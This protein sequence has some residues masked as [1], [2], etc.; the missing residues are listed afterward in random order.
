[1]LIDLYCSLPLV[2]CFDGE[3]DDPNA[4]GDD[5]NAGG[6][7]PN[8]GGDD[9]NKGKVFTQDEMNKILAEDK[10]KHKS[11]LQ[12]VEQQYETLLKSSQLT[13]KEREGLEES[14]ENVRKQML[15]Q[16]ERAK[17]EKKQ[18]QDKLTGEIESLR[19]RAETAERKFVESTIS[20]SLQ[21]AAVRAEAFNP[22][23]VVTILRGM[24][25]MVEDSPM[26]NFPGL[27]DRGEEVEL[28][29]TP[30]EAIERMKALPEQYGNL[31]KANLNG[32]LG[33]GSATGGVS[34]GANGRIDPRKIRDVAH[35]QRIRK[36]N[37]EALGLRRKG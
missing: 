25:K 12:K 23:Q 20:R 4:G 34:L 37:P 13:Q 11:Q 14:L 6:D 8:A 19:S 28:Q 29:M 31:F 1:M 5:P 33:A 30:D 27:N 35:Y 36:E 24:V 18:L 17:L 21:D 26:I 7:D 10:R 16:E 22:N 32:G 3:A 2:S 9:P 15:T